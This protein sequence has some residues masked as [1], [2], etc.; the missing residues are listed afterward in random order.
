MTPGLER[1]SSPTASMA[2]AGKSGWQ[3]NR[4]LLVCFGYQ[5]PIESSSLPL[6]SS[7]VELPEFVLQPKL[8]PNP[9]R[10]FGVRVQVDEEQE[11]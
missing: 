5:P 1:F 10:Q 3:L 4:I 8:N 9:A 7:G 11:N 6:R 2:L